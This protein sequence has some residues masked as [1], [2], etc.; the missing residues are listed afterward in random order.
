MSRR[1][2]LLIRDLVG[3]VRKERAANKTM[4]D[5]TK[6][7]TRVG[8]RLAKLN[9]QIKDAEHIKVKHVEQY[10]ESRKN[11][12]LS[13]RTLQNEM[14]AIR[15]VLVQA[16]KTQMADPNHERLSNQAL[17]IS[18][19]DRKGTKEAVSDERYR[20]ILARVEGRDE[21]VAAALRLSR[22]LGLRNEEAVQSAKSLKTWQTALQRGDE[23]LHVIFGT[24]GGRDRMTTVINR[25]KVLEAVN[26]ALKYS[27]NNNGKLINKDSLKSALNFYINVLRRDGGLQGGKETPHSFRYSYAQDAMEYH[28]SKGYDHQEVLALTSIDLGHGD[29]RGTYISNV[30]GQNK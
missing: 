5:Y 29:G 3:K 22:Y 16:G 20:E 30:Y 15:R 9:I 18:G 10:M 1:E 27:E 7:M 26:L 11:E 4:S 19:A 21:G 17:G 13:N 24:K 2:K 12:A 8:T 14:A 6:I 25:D 28:L 23:R